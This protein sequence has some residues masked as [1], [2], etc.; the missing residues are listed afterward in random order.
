MKSALIAPLLLAIT[1]SA[2]G[3]TRKRSGVEKAYTEEK[4]LVGYRVRYLGDNPELEK[5]GVQPG[6]ILQSLCGIKL[7]NIDAYIK[8]DQ[9]LMRGDKKCPIIFLRGSERQSYTLEKK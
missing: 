5:A 7:V 1:F 2:F 4:E 3:E 9:V 8:A 6:D